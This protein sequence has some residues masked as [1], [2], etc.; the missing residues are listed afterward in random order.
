MITL[1]TG[2]TRPQQTIF[3]KNKD[4]FLN[5]LLYKHRPELVPTVE[6]YI[7]DK[8]ISASINRMQFMAVRIAIKRKE[9]TAKCH[10][11]YKD[12]VIK[13]SEKGEVLDDSFPE[14]LWR[15]MLNLTEEFSRIEQQPPCKK[16]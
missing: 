4:K 2:R 10:F 9:L 12:H 14:G 15:E 16:R 5:E 1:N 6:L 3:M 13:I 7:D 8:F 11:K